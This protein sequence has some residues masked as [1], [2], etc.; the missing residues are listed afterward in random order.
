V[1][2]ERSVIEQRFEAVMAVLRD[3]EPVVEVAA[4]Y[5]VSRQ[6]VHTWIARYQNGG[7]G[8]Q[9]ARIRTVLRT[10]RGEVRKKKARR[11]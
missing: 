2:F 1:F 8:G 6:S 7:L 4:R 11:D 5:E 3:G 9:G 10:S